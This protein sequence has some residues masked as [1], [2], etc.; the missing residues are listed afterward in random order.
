MTKCTPYCSIDSLWFEYSKEQPL[1]DFFANLV[2]QSMISPQFSKFVAQQQVLYFDIS[3]T[4]HL[5]PYPKFK[6]TLH[7]I[8]CMH[9]R[10]QRDKRE[11]IKLRDQECRLNL[12]KS[13]NKIELRIKQNIKINATVY[14]YSPRHRFH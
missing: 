9:I 12:N 7:H 5:A 2:L 8:A 14:F 1:S 10:S 6:R 3:E 11:N 4:N 13:P